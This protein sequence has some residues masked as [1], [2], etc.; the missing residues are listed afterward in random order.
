MGIMGM[1]VPTGFDYIIVGD[2]F[3][4]KYP[5]YFNLTDNT[6]SFYNWN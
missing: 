5:S 4:R 6:V 2:V 3:I 1:E